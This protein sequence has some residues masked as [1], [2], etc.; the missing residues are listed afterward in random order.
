RRQPP[1]PALPGKYRRGADSRRPQA[2]VRTLCA[3]T[4]HR[5]RFWRLSLP[6]RRYPPLL[7]TQGLSPAA[8]CPRVNREK[9][10]LSS[11]ATLLD[12][13]TTLNSIGY[14]SHDFTTFHHEP[15]R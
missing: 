15:L 10:T 11:L 12:T 4:R 5:R 3:R 6:Q 7:R 2:A 13:G 1:E 9:W 8:D 14:Y